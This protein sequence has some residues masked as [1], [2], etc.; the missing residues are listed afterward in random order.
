MRTQLA[1]CI[2]QY[3]GVKDVEITLDGVDFQTVLTRAPSPDSGQ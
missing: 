3:D 1:S 2:W